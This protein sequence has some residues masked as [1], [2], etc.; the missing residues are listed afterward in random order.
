MTEIVRTEEFSRDLKKLKK[1]YNS[2]DDDMKVFEKALKCFSQ[3]P[4]P[5]TV[6]IAGLGEK[7]AKYPIYKVKSFRCRALQGKGSRSGM[8]IIFHLD[9]AQDKVFLIQIYHKSTTKNHDIRRILLHLREVAAAAPTAGGPEG[10]GSMA[11]KERG[12]R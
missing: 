3:N 9:E 12:G 6:R 7:Y 11:L 5:E 4:I 1:K 8:R 2:L 10:S